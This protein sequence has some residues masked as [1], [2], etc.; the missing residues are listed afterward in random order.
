MK[1]LHDS[2]WNPTHCSLRRTC[3]LFDEKNFT[4]TNCAVTYE[5]ELCPKWK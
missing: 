4:C 2:I 1:T 5:G 3:P